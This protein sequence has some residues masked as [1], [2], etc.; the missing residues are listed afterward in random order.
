MSKPEVPIMK[1]V[2][3]ENLSD[4]LTTSKGE[5]STESQEETFEPYNVETYEEFKNLEGSTTSTYETNGS[6]LNEDHK[7]E[8]LDEEISYAETVPVT[9]ETS[10]ST[11]TEE[12]KDEEVKTEEV[13]ESNLNRNIAISFAV[14][15]VA[16][17]LGLAYDYFVNKDKRYFFN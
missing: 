2:N 17:G 16:F 1:D 5:L 3:G 12:S 14:L 8:K 15:T 4:L 9:T 11:K 10:D 7:V 6:L 13:S